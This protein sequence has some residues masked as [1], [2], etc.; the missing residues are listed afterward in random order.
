MLLQMTPSP[1][2]PIGVD[3]GLALFLGLFLFVLVI[4]AVTYDAWTRNKSPI[5]WALI[6]AVSGPLGILLYLAITVYD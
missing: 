2:G 4:A 1:S 6:V 3:P 5:L